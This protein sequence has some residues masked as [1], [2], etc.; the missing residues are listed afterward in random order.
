[1]IQVIHAL[2]T[3]FI[4]WVFVPALLLTI[5]FC[6]ILIINF[7]KYPNP[8]LPRSLLFFVLI[9]LTT[10]VLLVVMAQIYPLIAEYKEIRDSVFDSLAMRIETLAYMP[11]RFAL[12][13]LIWGGPIVYG[14]LLCV[15]LICACLLFFATRLYLKRKP[16]ELGFAAHKDLA[17][18][19]VLWLNMLFIVVFVL[20]FMLCFC[21]FELIFWLAMPAIFDEP[22]SFSFLTDNLRKQMGWFIYSLSLSAGILLVI[23]GSFVVKSLLLS[24]HSIDRLAKTLKAVE[25]TPKR[26]KNHRKYARLLNVVE[27]IAI[28]S[29]MPMPRVFVMREEQGINAMC[30][31]ERF[32][33]SDERFALFF[34]QGALDTLSREELSG[35][36]GHEFSHA[37]H[38]DVALNLRIFS[39]IFGFMSISFIGEILMH[40]ITR[41]TGAAGKRDSKGEAVIALF[42]F[43]FYALGLLG[44][45]CASLIQAAISR[46]K[47]FLAD[48]TSVQ[49][50]HN[51]NAILRA[52]QTIAQEQSPKESQGRKLAKDTQ[53]F[54]HNKLA[55]PCAH[56]FFLQGFKGAFATHPPI[57]KRIEALESIAR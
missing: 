52:L 25:I 36:V 33:K 51:P 46:Q 42:A 45:L 38:Q 18:G 56:M 34:T 54:L 22:D 1:M 21:V 28:A 11:L 26:Y 43:S 31:G 41:R 10:I 50:T 16:K 37:F 7:N 55:K 32:G 4:P 53:G 17:L 39:L 47:E 3:H 57:N 30:S 49:Y 23:F 48:A 29:A 14:G 20:F 19:K 2:F 44:T 9:G 24:R 27:E 15:V 6:A 8:S 12:W 5:G 35:V 13:L 40:S